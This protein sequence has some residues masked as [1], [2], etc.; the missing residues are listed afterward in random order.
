MKLRK[1]P[2]LRYIEVWAVSLITLQLE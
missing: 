2:K 1:Q